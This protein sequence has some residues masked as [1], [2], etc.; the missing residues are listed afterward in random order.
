MT[1]GVLLRPSAY[2]VEDVRRRPSDLGLGA[3][4][5]RRPPEVEVVVEEHDVLRARPIRLASDCARDRCVLDETRDDHVLTL[6]DV[7][8]DPDGQLGVP[9]QPLVRCH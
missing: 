3:E 5:D 1:A 8:S 2:P 4:L 9:T 6:L 7:C